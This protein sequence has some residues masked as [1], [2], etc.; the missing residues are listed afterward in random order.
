MDLFI[1]SALALT[2]TSGAQVARIVTE[3]WAG[4]NLYCPAC[5]S[6]SIEPTP[7]GTKVVDFRCPDCE[8]PF[9]LKSQSRPFRAR[10]TDAA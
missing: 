8:E 2:Y 7:P 4:V 3:T 10:V 6:D 1:D 5:S 9:Q